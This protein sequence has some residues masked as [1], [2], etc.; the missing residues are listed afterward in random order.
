[1]EKK[2][3]FSSFIHNKMLLFCSAFILTLSAGVFYFGI[4]FSKNKKENKMSKLQ[5][6]EEAYKLE[7]LKTADRSLGYIPTER[8]LIAKA[9]MERQN[10]ERRL[11]RAPVGLTWTERGPSNIGG[12]TRAVIFD[13]ND[14]T[15][16]KVWAGGVGGGFF[17]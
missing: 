13:K 11:L 17:F 6:I 1:M 9:Q 8:L 16:K 3:I 12:R 7:F 4:P 15:N 14:M 5:A 10:A 2:F